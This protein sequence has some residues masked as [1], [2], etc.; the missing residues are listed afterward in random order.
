MVAIIT[1]TLKRYIIQD[2]IN[3]VQGVDQTYYIGIG[4]SQDWDSSDTTVVPTNAS[5]TE[6]D[7]RLNLQSVKRA[8]DVSYVVPRINWTTGT[9]YSGYNSNTVGQPSPSNYVLTDDNNVFLCLEQGKTASGAATPSI[10]RPSSLL[11][12]PERT[13]DGY[14][15]KYLFTLS[16]ARANKFLSANYLPVELQG[17][18]DSSSSS[19]ELGN[20]IIQNAATPGEINA[21]TVTSGG[22]GYTSAPTV[23]II[24]NG[25]GASAVAAISS[26]A[27]VNVQMKDSAAGTLYTPG[28]GYDYASVSFT[29]GGGTGASARVNIGPKLGFGGNPVVDLKSTAI[30]FNTKPSGAE[31]DDFII[32]QDF[33]QIGLMKNVEK[34]LN[35]SDY[36]S[37]TGSALTTMTLSSVSS[38]FTSNKQIIGDTSGAVAYVDKFDSDTIYY[39]Q[40]SATGFTAFQAAELLTETNGSG[41]GVIGTPLTNG[42]INRFKGDVLYIDNRA[43]ITRSAAQSEDLKIIIQL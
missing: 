17:L 5:R 15:W 28:S 33:R 37:A 4:R 31:N 16:A 10:I 11:T 7:F 22:T 1:D 32:D 13:A 21:I 29:G 25:T 34:G 42:D 38:P 20:E 36:T 40:D 9:I 23:S 27:V 3:E 35:D 30:M 2:I 19:I 24:G 26:G 39:H 18:T 43:A 41:S 6:K 8:D 14:V 12:T